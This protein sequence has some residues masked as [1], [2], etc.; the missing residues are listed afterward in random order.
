MPGVEF[1]CGERI[2][3]CTIEEEDVEVIQRAYNE[4]AFQQGFLIDS[5]KN[6]RM[7]E[8]RIEERV[9]GDD[10]SV[11]L[12][13]CIDGDAVGGVSLRDV[14]QSHGMLAYWL[15][16]DE[17]GQGYTTEAAA[18]LLDHAFDTM[19]L[20]RVFA[21]TIDDNEASQRVLRHLGFVHEGTYRE[22][23]FSEG[24]YHDTE[25]YGLLASGW[26]GVESDVSGQ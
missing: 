2:T 13:V 6:R 8:T 21:W 7:I 11:Y 1:L 10:D 24:E 20:H 3:L 26:N 9:V 4:P 15:L 17:R 25:H 19:G 18:L 5:P 23:V 14:R 12:L 22:H 16:P